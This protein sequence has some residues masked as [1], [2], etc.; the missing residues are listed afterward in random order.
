M[1]GQNEKRGKARVPITEAFS[2]SDPPE[3]AE[4]FSQDDPNTSVFNSHE[5]HP[6][7]ILV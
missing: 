5:N 1:P 2:R 6:S 7:K 3:V 4:A